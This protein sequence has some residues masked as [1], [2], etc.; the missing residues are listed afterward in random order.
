MPFG[1]PF[2]LSFSSSSS[3]TFFDRLFRGAQCLKNGGNDSSISRPRTSDQPSA[4]PNKAVGPSMSALGVWLRIGT[5]ARAEGYG[6][7]A[8]MVTKELSRRA[9]GAL[10]GRCGPVR[11]CL[12]NFAVLGA[13]VTH[14]SRNFRIT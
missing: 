7:G 3:S 13:F 1:L 10:F 9:A 6:H 4:R 11:L 14:L 2:G 5:V 8:R 12:F